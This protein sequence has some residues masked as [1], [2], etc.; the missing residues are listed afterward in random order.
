MKIY[1]FAVVTFLCVFYNY[2]AFQLGGKP[3]LKSNLVHNSAKYQ[4]RSLYTTQHPGASVERSQFNLCSGRSEEIPSHKQVAPRKLSRQLYIMARKWLSTIQAWFTE[5][6]NRR[7]VRSAPNA[8]SDVKISS[9]FLSATSVPVNMVSNLK[10]GKLYAAERLRE[11]EVLLQ[12]QPL[13]K[14]ALGVYNTTQGRTNHLNIASSPAFSD[15]TTQWN[16]YSAKEKRMVLNLT[17]DEV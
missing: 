2:R 15:N 17:Q 9:T 8:L 14:E 7:P 4:Q 3:S 6:R 11:I 10:A 12:K 13:E 16:I 5:G 1:V